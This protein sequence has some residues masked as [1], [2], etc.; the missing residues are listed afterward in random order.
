MMLGM[1]LAVSDR[2]IELPS[3]ACFHS[4]LLTVW[5]VH[6]FARLKDRIS[7]QRKGPD[8]VKTERI[9]EVE[10]VRVRLHHGAL[11]VVGCL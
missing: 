5:L 1:L 8:R 6:L 11:V 9:H 2:D 4:T 7:G 3:V 10:Q